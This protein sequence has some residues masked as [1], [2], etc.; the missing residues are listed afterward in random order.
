MNMT[1]TASGEIR[2][3]FLE[4]S[5][6]TLT[7]AAPHNGAAFFMLFNTKKNQE[8]QPASPEVSDMLF[9]FYCRYII[10]DDT[11]HSIGSGSFR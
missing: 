7:A 10:A 4:K 5:D 6:N 2:T 11:E 3:A 8:R 1:H 9:E